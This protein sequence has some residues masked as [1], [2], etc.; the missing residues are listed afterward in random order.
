MVTQQQVLEDFNNMSKQRVMESRVRQSVRG[1]LVEVLNVGY[2][3]GTRLFVP[4]HNRYV[5]MPAPGATFLVPKEIAFF[6]MNMPMG[7]KLQLVRGGQ[8]PA[9]F[10]PPPGFKLVPVEPVQE[11]IDA[12]T[13][14]EQAVEREES[15]NSEE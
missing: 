6:F 3:Q 9:N 13:M 15:L 1:G 8:K 7:K 11:E 5:E 12:E 2:E 4:R 10:T 14:L